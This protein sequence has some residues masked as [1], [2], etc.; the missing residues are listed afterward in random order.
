MDLTPIT[1]R[2][3]GRNMDDNF[4]QTVMIVALV[5]IVPIAVYYRMRSNAT[6]EKLDRTQEGMFLLIG[7]R[8]FAAVH[9]LGVFAFFISPSFMSWS[10]LPAPT[11]LRLIGVLC[12]LLGGLLW[13]TTFHYLGKNLTDTV[14][15]RKDHSLVTNGPYAYI[16][17]PFY[18]SFGLLVIANGLATANWFI[19]I[20][21]ALV[22]L[23]LY[24]RTAKEEA[25]LIERFG[26]AYRS[27][28]RTTGRFLPKLE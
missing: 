24:L 15:T 6:G 9:F 21:G 4:F 8:A 28:M 5:M 18:I 10:A 13:I 27:Y 3:N 17:H 19:F 12:A 26:D 20:S 2:Y 23:L 22:F 25:R 14:V 11:W 16:R 1:S 7:I